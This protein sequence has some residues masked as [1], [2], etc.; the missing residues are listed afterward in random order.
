MEIIKN[1]TDNRKRTWECFVDR[2]FFDMVCVRVKGDRDFNS[3]LS[4]HFYTVNQA[5]DF[6]K[7]LKDSH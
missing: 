7:L 6:M 2:S 4:F 3:Q 5:F 1:V